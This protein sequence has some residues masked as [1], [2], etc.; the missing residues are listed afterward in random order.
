M[1]IY[2]GN[3]ININKNN[4]QNYCIFK[5]YAVVSQILYCMVTVGMFNM[6]EVIIQNEKVLIIFI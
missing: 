2:D 5:F 3:S 1:F 4:R 6:L